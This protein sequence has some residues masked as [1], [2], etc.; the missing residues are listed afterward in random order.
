MI[1]VVSYIAV[2]SCGADFTGEEIRNCK[3]RWNEHITGKDKN[4]NFVKHLNHNF[5]HE[6]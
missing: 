3:I 2:C 4:S 1:I 6:F 5:D